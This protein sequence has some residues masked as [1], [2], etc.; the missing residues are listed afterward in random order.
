MNDYVLYSYFFLPVVT[1]EYTTEEELIKRFGCIPDGSLYDDRMAKAIR[2]N[3]RNRRRIEEGEDPKIH[4]LF[5]DIDDSMC[6]G[7]RIELCEGRSW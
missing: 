6:K 2:L 1:K 5:K 3:T 4:I 7:M